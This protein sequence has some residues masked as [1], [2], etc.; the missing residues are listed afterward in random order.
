MDTEE[1]KV[2]NKTEKTE[3]GKNSDKGNANNWAMG[4]AGYA[5]GV[6]SMAAKEVFAANKGSNGNDMETPSAVE[7]P[8]EDENVETSDNT[9][10]NNM[11]EIDPSLS[12]SQEDVILA[13]DEG[14][15]VAQVDDNVSFS[16]A[17]ADARAQ[18]GPGGVFEWRGKVY[19]TY[20]KEEWDNMSRAER[21]EYQ[22]KID[23]KDVMH[24]DSQD[25]AVHQAST[26]HSEL[27]DNG[28][29]RIIGVETVD[30]PNGQQMTVAGIEVNGDQ[31]LLVDLDDNGTMDI[32][33]HDDNG[34]GIIQESEIYDVSNAGVDVAD[35]E[36]SYAQQN[37]LHY[38][39]N[40]GLPDYM[41]DADVTPMV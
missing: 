10:N 28:D 27:S 38:A 40:D 25:S 17:F 19:G 29:I 39:S 3:S 41:N 7:S 20:Y 9:V 31:A 23:Y 36:Q 5:A 33:V 37:N 15:R 21:A 2:I 16:Q 22:S 6:A 18:V 26:T 24:H 34:D 12:P 30:G 8:I 13:T 35:L 4:V 1:T 11:P 14:V 32:L